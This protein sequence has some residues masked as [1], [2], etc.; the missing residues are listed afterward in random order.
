MVLIF[1]QS[2][3]AVSLQAP[4]GYYAITNAIAL[5]RCINQKDLFVPTCW[6]WDISGLQIKKILQGLGEPVVWIVFRIMASCR[7]VLKRRKKEKERDRKRQR[8]KGEWGP[9]CQ[10]MKQWNGMS[11]GGRKTQFPP[12]FWA[13]RA[14]CEKLTITQEE[15]QVAGPLKAQPGPGVTHCQTALSVCMC[16]SQTGPSSLKQHTVK[17]ELEQVS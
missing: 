2:H 13:C 5:L 1:P 6:L 12:S 16:V 17:T 8:K 9:Q 7:W 11:S 15:K 10:F 14:D 4:D 3:V